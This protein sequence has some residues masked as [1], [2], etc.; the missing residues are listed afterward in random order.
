MRMHLLRLAADLAQ[1][2]EPFAML[3][4]VRREAPSSAHLG[5]GAI[6]TQGG[7]F[8]GWLGGS[9]AQPAA[10]REALRSLADGAPRLIALSP[11]A[12]PESRPGVTVLPMT[13]HSGG[14]VDIYIEPVLPAPLLLIFGV[15]PIAQALARLG[16]VMGYD[17]AA[18]DPLAEQALFPEADHVF[19][20]MTAEGLARRAK[21]NPSRLY[22]VV[23]SMG[24]QD[25]D[26]LRVALDF[27]PAYLAVISSRTRFAHLKETLLAEGR[28]PESVERVKSPAGLDI[29]A[30]S[31]QEIALSIVAEI[32][33]RRRSVCT[34]P[35][36]AVEEATDPVCGMTVATAT[37]VHFTE[38][39]G[40]IYHFCGAG[41]RTRFLAEPKQFVSFPD[42]GAPRGE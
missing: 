40:N 24:D 16:K 32:V 19:T 27:D 3:T 29:G 39:G 8:H 31:P 4:V 10:I 15:S 17:V 25:I 35:Q 7:A 26:S 41:C 38:R 13:C 1:R 2:G 20:D 12:T 30:A 33:Q 37:S 9:C 21:A 28:D 5:D 23:A 34:T 22:A 14:S 42:T 11:D 18:V 36:A 6:V